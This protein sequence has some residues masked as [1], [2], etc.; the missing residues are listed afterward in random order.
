MRLIARLFG[1]PNTFLQDRRARAEVLQIHL[2]LRQ[3]LAP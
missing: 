3:F 2:E 1:F